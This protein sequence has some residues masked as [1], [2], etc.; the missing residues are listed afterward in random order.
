MSQLAD[1][2]VLFMSYMQV[3]RHILFFVWHI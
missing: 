3:T 1:K 2:S